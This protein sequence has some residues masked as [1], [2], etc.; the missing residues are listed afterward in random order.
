LERLYTSGVQDPRQFMMAFMEVNGL[1][2][3]LPDPLPPVMQQLAKGLMVERVPW[4]AQIPLV[5]LRITPF[6]KLIVS[7]AESHP[8]LTAV[9]D[10]L[11]QRLAAERVVLPE[12]DHRIM[13][14]PDFNSVLENFLTTTEQMV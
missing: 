6:P 1:A 3:Q 10:V 8:A 7:G 4:E 5:D 14:S 12:T 13:H 11:E 9:C 2:P